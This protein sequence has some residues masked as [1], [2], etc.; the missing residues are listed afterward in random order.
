VSPTLAGDGVVVW[1]TRQDRLARHIELDGPYGI[2]GFSPTHRVFAAI[3]NSAERRVS[4]TLFLDAH[5]GACVGEA[6]GHVA[7][8][9]GSRQFSHCGRWFASTMAELNYPAWY[10]PAPPGTVLLSDLEPILT[11][12]TPIDGAGPTD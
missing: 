5:T 7:T 9:D 8:G 10:N 1:D 4:R 11:Q 12:A 3:A 2:V 6:S